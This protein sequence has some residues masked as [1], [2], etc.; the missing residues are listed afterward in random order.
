MTEKI[1]NEIIRLPTPKQVIEECLAVSI[2]VKQSILR[3]R[4]A[5]EE[6]ISGKDSRLLVVVGPCS[7]HDVQEAKDYALKLYQTRKH[8]SKHLEIVMRVYLEKPRTILGWKGFINDP[9]L[10]GSFDVHTGLKKAR[11]LLVSLS[12]IGMP[13]A[14]EFLDMITPSYLEDLVSWGAIG[15]RTT[16]S[17]TH[18]ELASGLKC[19]VGFKNATHGNIKVAID[20]VKAAQSRHFRVTI[21]HQGQVSAVHT[22]GNPYAHIIL[23]GGVEPN[24]QENHIRQGAK[25]LME[26]GLTPKLM[27]DCSHGNSSKQYQRQCIVGL[28]LCRQISHGSEAIMGVMIESNLVAGRQDFVVGQ[29]LNYG[30]SITDACISWE[31]TSEILGQLASAVSH[32]N[33]RTQEES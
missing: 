19:P 9:H 30:Q 13:V 7:I 28:N 3:Y 26:R 21:D 11:N 31:E 14:C 6:I 29:K 1:S 25:A 17:Q 12:E 16:E 10:D 23:R 20:G 27:V 4:K 32:R 2:P 8:F 18:R 24:Y 22:K 33:A 5:I 15:A